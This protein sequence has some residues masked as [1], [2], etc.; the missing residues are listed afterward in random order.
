MQANGFN[1]TFKLETGADGMV[2]SHTALWLKDM[3]LSKSGIGL[4]G[5]EGKELEVLGAFQARMSYG[6][7]THTRTAYVINNQT[8]SLHSR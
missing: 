3:T 5:P 8:S 1:T 4:Y 7:R 6:D 2:I